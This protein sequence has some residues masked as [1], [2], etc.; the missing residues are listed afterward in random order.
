MET[1]A[2][3]TMSSIAD[4]EEL[5]IFGLQVP[6]S[7]EGVDAT[8]LNPTKAWANSSDWEGAAKNLAAQF[9]E[10]FKKYDVSD[11]IV[12]AGPQL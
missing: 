6:T 7:L 5:P 11:A 4:T 8:L 12:N 9:V 1:E 10:N 3:T 2:R